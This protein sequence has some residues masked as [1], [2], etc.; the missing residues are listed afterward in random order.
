MQA[1]K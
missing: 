1:Y